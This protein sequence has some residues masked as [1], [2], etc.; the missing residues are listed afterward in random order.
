M[1]CL[2]CNKNLRCI[3]TRHL[4]KCCGLTITEY[5]A[6]HPNAELVDD[7]VKQSYGSNGSL[8]PNWKGGINSP[9]C[10]ICSKP[11]SLHSYVKRCVKC[12]QIG[13]VNPFFGKWH[14]TY[15]KE[16]MKSAALNRDP[17][18]YKYGL[19]TSENISQRSR[20][21]WQALSQE[22][23]A[24]H[25]TNFIKAG[26]DAC[27]KNKDTLIERKIESLLNQLNITFQK[28]VPVGRYFVDF[29]IGDKI[30]ECYG[31]YWHVN[32]K[33]YDG[34]YQHKY[35]AMTAQE[36]W[37]KDAQRM[38]NLVNLGYQ[39]MILWE[40]DIKNNI[41]DVKIKIIDFIIPQND[42]I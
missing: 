1:Q 40:C 28:N 38:L 18:T 35:L 14:S 25:L 30:I 4:A 12:R 19:D 36:K 32:P 21:Y 34:S 15:T 23:K 20:L 6:K 22:E 24:K 37:D 13:K 3:N 9:K 17:N 7:D 42:L 26:H 10:E 16:K 29:L 27:R 39:A 8:N 11:L 41:D 33:I 31:D 2:E 5:L